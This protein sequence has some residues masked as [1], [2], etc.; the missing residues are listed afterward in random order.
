MRITITIDASE[1]EAAALVD[2]LKEVFGEGVQV[3]PEITA[4]A[5]PAPT[6]P[7]VSITETSA[8]AQPAASTA[9]TTSITSTAT[10]LRPVPP[11]GPPGRG[12]VF[13]NTNLTGDQIF[14]GENLGGPKDWWISDHVGVSRPGGETQPIR[15]ELKRPDTSFEGFDRYLAETYGSTAIEMGGAFRTFNWEFHQSDV[16]VRS[17]FTYDLTAVFHPISKT[18]NDAGAE[19]FMGI[20][21]AG[22]WF[23]NLEWR[24]VVKSLSGDVLAQ[25]EWRDGE[26]LGTLSFDLPFDQ[27]HQYTYSWVCGHSEAVTF[28]VEFRNKWAIAVT[29]VWLHAAACVER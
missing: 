16:A 8:P 9:S 29:K 7:G 23:S 11:S 2:K 13:K 20:D 4:P 24:W 27:P 17:G 21:E 6:V 22:D 28:S 19:V 25:D 15:S 26:T 3:E 12:Q 14:Y 10:D 18:K 5:Q 1:V